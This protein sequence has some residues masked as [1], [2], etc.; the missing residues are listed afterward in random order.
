MVT[1]DH[2]VGWWDALTLDRGKEGAT[3]AV[4]QLVISTGGRRVLAL[5]RADAAGRSITPRADDSK[6]VRLLFDDA[7]ED[8]LYDQWGLRCGVSEY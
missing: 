5:I 1:G 3:N 2:P 7:M 6:L 8:V 4:A